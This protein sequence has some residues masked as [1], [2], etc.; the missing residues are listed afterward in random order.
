M[1][2]VFVISA[3]SVIT[4]ITTIDVMING[5]VNNVVIRLIATHFVTSYYY[6]C[7]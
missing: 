1:T 6:N 3:A 5:T 2:V 4:N 7:Y